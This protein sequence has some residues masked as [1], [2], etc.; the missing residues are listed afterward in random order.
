MQNRDKRL[1][2]TLSTFIVCR[3]LCSE[4]V[5][6]LTLQTCVLPAQRLTTSAPAEGPEGTHTAITGTGEAVVT[7][8]AGAE[9][10][11][12]T[13]SATGAQDAAEG[14]ARASSTCMDDVA[15]ECCKC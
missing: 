7:V 9:A 1:T 10:G 12:A 15:S 6:A 11:M 3:L 14:S 4:G 2:L 8:A 13:G 5:A